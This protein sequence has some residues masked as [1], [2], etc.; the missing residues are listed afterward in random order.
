MG[1]GKRAPVDEMRLSRLISWFAPPTKIFGRLE[2]WIVPS[3]R[4]I[5]VCKSRW[6]HRDPPL[7]AKSRKLRGAILSNVRLLE[8]CL[9]QPGGT[10]VPPVVCRRKRAGR[11]CSLVLQTSKG[12]RTPGLSV[13]FVSSPW[14]R[15]V[16]LSSLQRRP[17]SSSSA[18]DFVFCRLRTSVSMASTAGSSE[19]SLR[20]TMTRESSSG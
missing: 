12:L 7:S 9:A 19:S 13:P 14:L 6:G 11:P 18:L 5:P 2:R 3:R 8:D 1:S 10:G 16:C 15:A 17:R 4:D 20:R